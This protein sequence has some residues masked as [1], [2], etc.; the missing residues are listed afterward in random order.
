MDFLRTVPT[1]DICSKAWDKLVQRNWEQ[2]K[3]AKGKGKK[4]SS[5]DPPKPRRNYLYEELFGLPDNAARFMRRFFLP[6]RVR[7]DD[8]DSA[9]EFFSVPWELIALFIRKVVLMDQK[10]INRIC[11]LGDGLAEYVRSQGG[12]GKRFFRQFSKE[13]KP[14]QIRALLMKANMDV[15]KAGKPPLFDMYGYIDVFEEG[16]EVMYADW[17]LARDLVLMRMIDQLK[18]TWLPGNLDVLP[19]DTDT[20]T[21]TEAEAEAEAEAEGSQHATVES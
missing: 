18:D 1:Q 3:P 21:D 14:S 7:L 10:R 11:E 5:S 2:V 16:F 15:I 8:I 19:E 9:M 13:R 4:K 17:L 20:D 6:R 12:Y